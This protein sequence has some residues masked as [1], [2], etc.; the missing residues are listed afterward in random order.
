MDDI[1]IHDAFI[2]PTGL[3]AT[4]IGLAG[5]LKEWGGDGAGRRIAHSY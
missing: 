4:D 3:R 1:L 2:S 5:F